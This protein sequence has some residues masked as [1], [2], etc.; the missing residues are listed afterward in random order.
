[1]TKCSSKYLGSPLYKD[2]VLWDTLDKSTQDLPNMKQLSRILMKNCRVYIDLLQ[3][4][5][6]FRWM[7]F[8]Y[9]ACIQVYTFNNNNNKNNGNIGR[10]EG[11]SEYVHL[12]LKSMKVLGILGQ[13]LF[14]NL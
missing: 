9:Y 7:T 14:E 13:H 3:W 4:Y 2:S 5:N 10:P 6:N 11:D 1:M 12:C 8:F